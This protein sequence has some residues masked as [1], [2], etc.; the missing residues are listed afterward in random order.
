MSAWE[1]LPNAAPRFFSTSELRKLRGLEEVAA[2]CYR[3]GRSGIQFLLVQTRNG[4][5]T[6]PKGGVE[7]DLTHAQ[8]AA[9]EAFEEAGVHGRMEEG[10]FASYVRYK[11]RHGAE[12]VVHAHLCEVLRTGR[13]KESGRNPTWFSAA[14]AKERLQQNRNKDFATQLASVVD[15]AVMRIR[16]L[17]ARVRDDELQRVWFDDWVDRH[18]GWAPDIPARA[19]IP[20]S[21]A[22]ALQASAGVPTIFQLSRPPRLLPAGDE[23][24]V[25]EK[26]TKK[27]N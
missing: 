6:F 3:I 25:T 23:P 5:W 21:A 17:A 2:V 19:E 16:R 15:R 22:V 9:L 20:R 7:A 24:A 8:S 13:P 26:L 10:S 14:K 12:L 27:R 4:R 18:T 11:G 1:S